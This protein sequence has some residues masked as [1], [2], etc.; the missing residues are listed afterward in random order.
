MAPLDDPLP[1]LPVHHVAVVVVEHAGG[2]G[3]DDDHPRSPEV[4]AARPPR[5]RRLAIRML[6]ERLQL[7][8]DVA[9]G[10]DRRSVH[11]LLLQLGRRQV[12][13]V[14]IEPVG[15]ERAGDPRVPPRLGA[16]VLEPPPRDVPVVDDVV[17]V[18]DH[19]AGDGREQ[20]A[21]VGICPRLA[22]ETGV[23]LEVRNLLA[24]RLRRVTPAADER[25]RLGRHLVGVD[26]VATQEERVGPGLDAGLEP[27]RVRPQGID[28]EAVLV[29]VWRQRVRLA[30]RGADTARTEHEPCRVLA[31]PSVDCAGRA[32]AI[33]RGPDPL[34]V[35][36]HL[37]AGH[38]TL[39]Q[40]LQHHEGVMM[41]A[42]LERAGDVAEHV[43]V[44]RA[45][46]LDP[47]GR[48][49]APDVAEQRAENERRRHVSPARHAPG[50][51]RVAAAR[52]PGQAP[53]RARG[54]SGS[55][56]RC[57]CP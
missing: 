47:Y 6:G 48:L 45:V 56:D 33:G 42:H 2:P 26:L 39:G 3:V 52:T 54:R 12:S 32:P 16:G 7:R 24:W 18:E 55:C 29:V 20:P 36:P 27:A 34:A 22:I 11:R 14:L 51:G 37:V 23:L 41:A 46:R 8:A 13:E 53:R 1:F 4:P 15:H 19:E 10:G 50:R 28:P 49:G 57:G 17:V 35:Q 43:D 38:R 31:F 25:G 40:V 9:V 21:D 30:L 5:G 44:A